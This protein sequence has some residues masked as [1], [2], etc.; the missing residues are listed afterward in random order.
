MKVGGLTLGIQA[1]NSW[2]GRFNRACDRK[3]RSGRL[4]VPEEIHKMFLEKGTSK[5]R[6]FEAFVRAN[7]DKDLDAN[8]ASSVCCSWG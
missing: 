8:G 1:Y 7:G 3:Q 4:D 5:D 2:R 6:L